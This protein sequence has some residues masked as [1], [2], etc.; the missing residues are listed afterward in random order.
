MKYN[1][2]Y[3]ILPFLTLALLFF[4]LLQQLTGFPE[5]KPL[6]GAETVVEVP[7]L[8]LESYTNYGYQRGVE[9][10]IKQNM[11][12][13]YLFIPLYNQ[14]MWSLY[15]KT[16]NRFIV[17]GKE[18]YLLELDEVCDYL[19]LKNN[20]Y[21]PSTYE[22]STMCDFEQKMDN[23]ATIQNVL[24]DSNVGFTYILNPSKA[25]T[26]SE[27]I[28]DKMQYV[29]EPKEFNQYEYVRSNK[30]KLK[31]DFID[32]NDWFV[33]IKDSVDFEIFN[34]TAKHWSTLS[35]MMVLD[36]LISHIERKK[37]IKMTHIDYSDVYSTDE[38]LEV[39]YDLEK[40]MN[41]ITPISKPPAKYA[42]LKY[43]VP[44][45][46]HV[47]PKVI[48]ISDSYWWN[49]HNNVDLN[50]IFSELQFW[51]YY[52]TSYKYGGNSLDVGCV[53][54]KKELLDADYVF[55]LSLPCQLN[56]LGWSFNSKGK[57]ILTMKDIDYNEY[58]VKAALKSIINEMKTNKEW[59]ESLEQKAESRGVPL[60][61][62]MSQDA[63]WMYKTRQSAG[64]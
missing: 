32:V 11:G 55:I 41:L 64:K 9:S 8:S 20:I 7:E 49:I 43:I 30:D 45:D 26:H 56:Q 24:N 54:V 46:N 50:K 61:T 37:G 31:F 39:D 22:Y 6:A 47:K 57:E 52:N 5:R 27:Y 4:P 10:Y 21:P 3:R 17:V 15:R 19:N 25:Y 33:N 28:P 18:D 48:V 34:K 35:S 44:E 23:L 58:S 16:S 40:L 53:D 36:S 13:R 51:Y 63:R 14:T 29:G 2:P 59:L 62:V 38:Y 42:K 12:F 1:K 60:D